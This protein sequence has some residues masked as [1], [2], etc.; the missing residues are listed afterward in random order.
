LLVKSFRNGANSYMYWNMILDELGFSNWVWRQNSMISINK[1]TR[2]VEFNPEF[3]IM[4]HFSHFIKPGAR[5]IG[6]ENAAEKDIAF[7]NP[8]GSIIL[9]TANTTD[10][11]ITREFTH[12]R[13]TLQFVVKP[14]TV[15]TVK[16]E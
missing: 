15:Y 16:F 2:E 5:R 10:A 12:S 1:F 8:D 6:L 9:I 4:K 7:Q 14:G 13:N 11:E 3:Y